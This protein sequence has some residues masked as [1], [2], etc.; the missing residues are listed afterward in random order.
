MMEQMKNM[1]IF[2]SLIKMLDIIEEEK[3]Q[4]T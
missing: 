1:K 3:F 2:F 4:S